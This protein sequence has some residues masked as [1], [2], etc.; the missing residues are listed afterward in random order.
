EVLLDD[1]AGARPGRI[2]VRV[3]ARPEDV[4]DPGL[5]AELHAGMVLD[6]GRVSLTV[7]VRAR[8]LGDDR[9][10][11]EAVLLEGRVHP[12]EEVRDPSDAGLDH[13]EVE[14]RM[15]LADAAEDQLGDQ[16]A[17]AERGERDERLA[18]A[19]GR[20]EEALELRAT[21]SLDVEGERDAGLL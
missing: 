3:V 14:A 19:R 9:L 2:A 8:R 10:R 16:L 21:R 7:P 20:V 18:D 4:L 13:D 12:L 6:E 15:A 1:L 11:P 17:D 5:V